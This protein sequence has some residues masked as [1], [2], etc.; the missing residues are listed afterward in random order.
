MFTDNPDTTVVQGGQQFQQPMS[1]EIP[2]HV[3]VAGSQPMRSQF[4]SDFG[5]IVH[6]PF[7]T[8]DRDAVGQ[9]LRGLELQV[10]N[11]LEG[12]RG[13]QQDQ[14]NQQMMQQ[15]PQMVNFPNTQMQNIQNPH[16]QNLPMPHQGQGMQ[17]QG[18][19]QIQQGQ[20]SQGIQPGSQG[21]PVGPQGVQSGLQG[22]Q[23]GLQGVQVPMNGQTFPTGNQGQGQIPQPQIQ[24]S[25]PL[26]PTQFPQ[27]QQMQ[28]PMVQNVVPVGPQ[29][30]QFLSQNN[31]QMVQ[32][33]MSN[34][35]VQPTQIGMLS[36][37]QGQGQPI[38]Q[39]RRRRRQ[40]EPNCDK[41]RYDP[42]T[43]CK[44]YEAQCHNCT[45]EKRLRFE[46]AYF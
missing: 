25:V 45:L 34:I 24:Q 23:P 4:Q 27:N 31:G 14:M 29:G 46:G 30:Q 21:I 8:Q 18:I 15:N 22:I 12:L 42:E 13:W 41:L 9:I 28:Q 40:I 2:V 35:P 17:G 43:Y 6:R 19:Q 36:N 16:M 11:Q 39:G 38:L 1:N 10:Q 5:P 44:T 32:V 7:T 20:F 37:R 26:S 33:P 3:V